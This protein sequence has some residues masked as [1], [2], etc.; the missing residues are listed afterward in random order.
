MQI[1]P[2]LK[3]TLVGLVSLGTS[4]TATGFRCATSSSSITAKVGLAAVIWSS[5]LVSVTVAA[6]RLRRPADRPSAGKSSAA[7]FCASSADEAEFTRGMYSPWTTLASE[8]APPAY[9]QIR[10]VCRLISNSNLTGR[11]QNR[12]SSG[13]GRVVVKLRELL[14]GD[15]EISRVAWRRVLLQF[16]RS[17]QVKTRNIGHRVLVSS[18]ANCI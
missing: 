15:L 18:N 9:T 2:I 16:H 8:R 10:E 3:H 13:T 6:L 4:S 11:V 5:A 7:N 17:P 1:S 14:L 12:G